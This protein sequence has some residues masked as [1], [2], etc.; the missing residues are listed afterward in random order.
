MQNFLS[1][2][3]VTGIQKISHFPFGFPFFRQKFFFV[4]AC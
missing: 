1:E 4:S 3:T 2:N